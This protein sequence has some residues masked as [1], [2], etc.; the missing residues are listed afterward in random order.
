MFSRGTTFKFPEEPDD[1]FN[2]DF[3]KRPRAGGSKPLTR[4]AEGEFSFYEPKRGVVNPNGSKPS[5]NG[6]APEPEPMP[7]RI[8]RGRL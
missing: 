2:P 4:A 7:P 1:G 3:P 8:V 6:P 5:L